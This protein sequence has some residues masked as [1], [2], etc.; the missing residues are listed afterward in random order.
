MLPL[1]EGGPPNVP[2]ETLNSIEQCVTTRDDLIA[3]IGEP[4]AIWDEQRVFIYNEGSSGGLFMFICAPYS[5]GGG[6][7]DFGDDVILLRFDERWRVL[8]WD[9]RVAPAEVSFFGR[10]LREWEQEFDPQ[11]SSPNCLAE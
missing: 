7:I 5:C 1:G 3:L 11:A 2:D 9:R 6:T 10:F 4:Y 8:N